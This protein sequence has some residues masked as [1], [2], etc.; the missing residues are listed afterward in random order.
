MKI[1]SSFTEKFAVTKTENIGMT[2]TSTMKVMNM[3]M[4]AKATKAVSTC[5]T[6]MIVLDTMDIRMKIIGLKR[7]IIATWTLQSLIQK[8]NF[9]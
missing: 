3:K 6:I 4:T 7:M 9:R 8:M 1:L 2:I 5:T